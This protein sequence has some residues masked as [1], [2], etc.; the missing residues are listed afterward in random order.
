VPE[1]RHLSAPSLVHTVEPPSQLIRQ[2][3]PPG[4]PLRPTAAA[5][6]VWPELPRTESLDETATHA[7]GGLAANIW[8]T[9]GATPDTLTTAQRRS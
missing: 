5:A 2:S 9:D 3:A 6:S 1:R 7:G 4:Q 8:R